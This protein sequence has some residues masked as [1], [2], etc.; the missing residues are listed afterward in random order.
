M[1][2]KNKIV[3][4][5]QRRGVPF[6]STPFGFEGYSKKLIDNKYCFITETD[7]WVVTIKRLFGK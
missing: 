3:N 4:I 6:I 7:K 2:T 5:F 1:V